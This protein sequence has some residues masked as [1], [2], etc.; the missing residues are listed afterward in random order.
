MGYI[1]N[2]WRPLR[3]N[4]SSRGGI[5]RRNVDMSSIFDS[6][7]SLVPEATVEILCQTLDS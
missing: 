4:N 1:I 2:S 3:G 6:T 7:P 5:H